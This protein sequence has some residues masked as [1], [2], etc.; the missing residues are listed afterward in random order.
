MGHEVTTIEKEMQDLREA[1][2]EQAEAELVLC[3]EIR[4]AQPGLKVVQRLNAE[5]ERLRDRLLRV[6]D[7]RNEWAAKAEEYQQSLAAPKHNP[8]ASTGQVKN[9]QS[10]SPA[11]RGSSSQ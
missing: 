9:Q 7:Q 8:R 6:K 2:R 11:R 3:S 5:T 1:L 10:A 4:D